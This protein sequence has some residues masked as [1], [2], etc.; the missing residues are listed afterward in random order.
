MN[1]NKK[2]FHL[3][4]S[5]MRKPADLAARYLQDQNQIVEQVNQPEI[6]RYNAEI[7]WFHVGCLGIYVIILSVF[8]KLHK[9]I[10]NSLKYI[11]VLPAKIPCTSCRFF[12]NNY[13]LKCAVFPSRVL[14]K[15]AINCA[16]Y[17]PFKEGF[18]Q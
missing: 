18:K 2:E 9:N 13:Y 11:W 6:P 10:S 1:E 7:I 4:L 17:C 16:E 15:D 12:N 14:T 8:L 3:E 5:E